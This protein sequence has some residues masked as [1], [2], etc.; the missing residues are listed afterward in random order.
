MVCMH[1]VR[2]YVSALA[3]VTSNKYFKFSLKFMHSMQCEYGI[4]DA[5]YIIVIVLLQITNVD[6]MACCVSE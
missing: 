6:E 1:Y 2:A 3:S 5:Y 4:Y